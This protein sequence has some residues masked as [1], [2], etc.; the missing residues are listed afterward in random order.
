MLPSRAPSGCE[1]HVR[2]KRQ[3]CACGP[4]H[5]PQLL[6]SVLHRFYEGVG[7]LQTLGATRATEKVLFKRHALF[8][9][10]ASQKVCLDRLIWIGG[11]QTNFHT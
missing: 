11:A 3:L 8:L 9:G 4:T 1:G 7:K 6:G 5:A 2:E 10:Q